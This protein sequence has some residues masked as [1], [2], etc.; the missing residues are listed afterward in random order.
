MNAAIN[1][2]NNILRSIGT[3]I[4][5]SALGAVALA[6]AFPKAGQAWLAPIAAA[7]LF[8]AWRTLSW[9]RAFLLGWLAGAIFFS[10]N[11]SWFTYTVG[12][13]VGKVAFAVVL[14]PALVEGIAFALTAVTVAIAL[15]NSPRW[16]VPLAAAAAFTIFEWL[17]SIGIFAVPFAQ[18]GYSQ[19]TTPLAFFAPYIGSFG[20][21]FVVMLLGAYLAEAIASRNPRPL[22][23]VVFIVAVACV[24]CW[25]LWPARRFESGSPAFRV[26]AVQGNIPQTLKWNPQNFWLSV[27]TYL[28]QTRRLA[29][30][31]PLLVVLPETVIPTDFNG[32][33]PQGVHAVVRADFAQLA[34]LMHTWLIIGSLDKHNGHE[35]N[36]L[37]TLGPN[38]SI[39]N[40]YDKRQ[41]VPF[42]E[43]F[44]GEKVL[45]WLPGSDLIGRFAAGT[46]DTVLPIGALRVAPL[47][48]WESAFADLVHAQIER[49]AQVL[50]IAT[51]DAWFGDSSG[52]FQHAQIAQMRAIETGEYVLQSASTGISGVITPTG[53]WQD[54]APLDRQALIVSGV[55]APDSSLSLFARIGPTPVMLSLALLYVLIVG[56]GALQK[57]R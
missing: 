27:N 36:A 5:L 56:I 20:V 52:T 32:T 23:Y 57:R 18:I 1:T 37:F 15:A 17:R 41:L 54:T 53:R 14:I 3:S 2:T 42:T 45:G 13:Y 48:C 21:T 10:I 4:I 25:W 50:V 19:T 44:P 47:I 31:R 43:S 34:H 49:G 35:Y 22:A 30:L 24:F 51:D 26:A 6:F 12:A 55:R 8:W 46:I 38:G 29:P 39:V 9:K 40:I 28:N 11:F 33:D 7:G 16:A